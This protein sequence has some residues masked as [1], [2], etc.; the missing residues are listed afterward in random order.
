MQ[1]EKRN[2]VTPLWNKPVSSCNFPEMWFFFSKKKIPIWMEHGYEGKN[3]NV[4]WIC[5]EFIIGKNNS[6]Y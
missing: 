2:H 1:I 6:K 3:K 4:K 5:S